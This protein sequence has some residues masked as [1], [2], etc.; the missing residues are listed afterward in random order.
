MRP[1]RARASAA[2]A[3][4]TAVAAVALG[5]CGSGTPAAP[6]AG[7]SSAPAP[8]GASPTTT[9]FVIPTP[10]PPK[11]DPCKLTPAQIRG[12]VGFA[13][14]R[15][16]QS[17]PGQCEYQT[18]DTAGNVWFS[19]DSA[20]VEDEARAKGE[21]TFSLGGRYVVVSDETGFAGD[22]FTA[23]KNPG[24]KSPGVI[25]DL[26]AW[27]APGHLKIRVY[28]PQGGTPPGRRHVLALAH[29]MLG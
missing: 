12:V 7:G 13:V 15:K 17:S 23:V 8:A 19:V 9:R 20:D 4:V 2:V 1:S 21:D 28:Y 14:T 27:L 25:A 29:L 22:A 18:A 24:D 5:G 3:A 6:R 11:I 10:A 16:P 26:W